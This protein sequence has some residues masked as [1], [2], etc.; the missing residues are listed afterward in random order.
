MKLQHWTN[1]RS[2]LWRC[3]WAAHFGMKHRIMNMIRIP[4]MNHQKI[5]EDIRVQMRGQTFR[6]S[7]GRGIF[8]PCNELTQWSG[9]GSR[10]ENPFGFKDDLPLH[11]G[12][13]SGKWFIWA[14]VKPPLL[15][16]SATWPA[17]NKKSR[18][19]TYLRKRFFFHRL[20]I[21]SWRMVW[22]YRSAPGSVG[23][24]VCSISP[25]AIRENWSKQFGIQPATSISGTNSPSEPFAQ[26]AIPAD[27]TLHDIAFQQFCWSHQR[28]IIICFYWIKLQDP[29]I[30]PV[31]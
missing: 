1:S 2:D 27:I 4:C 17:L 15:S 22:L 28:I 30:I 5:F 14:S 12:F 21:R 10:E 23:P 19:L 13:G 18:R 29:L 31:W 9:I 8:R 24:R 25:N 3:V 26:A 11:G 7:S 16:V 6:L 20:S